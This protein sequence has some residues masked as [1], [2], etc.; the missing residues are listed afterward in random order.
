MDSWNFNK[1]FYFL[2]GFSS[3]TM[4]SVDYSKFQFWLSLS[5][6]LVDQSF[7]FFNFIILS[8]F[9][10]RFLFGSFSWLFR[11]PMAFPKAKS[12]DCSSTKSKHLRLWIVQFFI[13]NFWTRLLY[14]FLWFN[15]LLWIFASSS[16]P[17]RVLLCGYCQNFM[18]L[19]IWWC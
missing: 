6:F 19:C 7:F 14:S 13:L 11:L 2:S 17:K 1:G 5:D 15:S 18:P 10:A 12:F 4:S 3:T 16:R 9:H 8:F